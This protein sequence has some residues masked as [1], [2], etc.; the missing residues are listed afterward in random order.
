VRKIIVLISLLLVSLPSVVQ[1]QLVVEITE[2]VKRRP[3]AVVPFGW[4]GNAAEM[5]TDVA[6]IISNNLTRSGRFAPIPEDDMLQKPTSGVGMDFDDWSILGVEAVVVGSV[7]Q[8]GANAYEIRFPG[9]SRHHA[10]CGTPMFGYDLRG[11]DRH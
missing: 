5:P 10:S 11:A 2:G 9:K 3:V 4:E 8:T 1:A 6:E 7:R